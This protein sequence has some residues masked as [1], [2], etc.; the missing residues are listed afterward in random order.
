MNT[1]VWKLDNIGERLW[2]LA[3][4]TATV[5]AVLGHKGR[6][7]A[8][9]AEE[10]RRLA[11]HIK[12]VVAQAMEDKSEINSEKVIIYAEQL[13]Y[14]ALNTAIESARLSMDG[15]QA[16]VCA[17]EIRD[18]AFALRCLFDKGLTKD[19]KHVTTPWAAK[20]MTTVTAQGEFLLLDIGGIPVVEPLKNI[21]EILVTGYTEMERQQGSIHARNRVLPLADGYKLLGKPQEARFY[22]TYAIIDTP[23]AEQNDCYAVAA[24]VSCIFASPIGNPISVPADMPLA[25]YVRECWENENGE[26]FYFMDWGKMV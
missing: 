18:L 8:I 15:K 5:A 11:N 24:Q 23:W 10:T 16:A 20:P 19:H 4:T 6:G 14:L 26:P 12:D 25:K 9:V 2:S 17:E 22:A 3:T 1:T 13:N 21:R 7:M